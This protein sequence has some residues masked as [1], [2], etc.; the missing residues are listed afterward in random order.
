MGEKTY[1]IYL[2]KLFKYRNNFNI[3][4]IISTSTQLQKAGKL[5]Y[6]LISNKHFQIYTSYLKFN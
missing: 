5:Q 4:Y 3:Q 6:A 2:L 1:L